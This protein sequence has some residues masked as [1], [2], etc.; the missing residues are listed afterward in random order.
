M[1]FFTIG[2]GIRVGAGTV[3]DVSAKWIGPESWV[4]VRDDFFVDF[5]RI[6]LVLFVIAFLESV[7]HGVDGGLAVF[8][9]LH[10][11]EVC[12]LDKEENKK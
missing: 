2:W 5:F 8:V 4:D 10:G 11:I 3:A 1:T 9:A 6:I 12:F 7:V